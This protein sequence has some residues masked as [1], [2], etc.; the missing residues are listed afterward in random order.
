MVFEA[1]SKVHPDGT[2][3]AGFFNITCRDGTKIDNVRCDCSGLMTAIIQYMGYYTYRA[4]GKEYSDSYHGEGLSS[5]MDLS[6]IYDKEGNPTTDWEVITK[7]NCT[8]W[9]NVN[10]DNF[11]KTVEEAYNYISQKI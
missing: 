4:N 2:Y 1:L 7:E 5:S 11:N 3:D 10:L 8:N 6:Q 9:F